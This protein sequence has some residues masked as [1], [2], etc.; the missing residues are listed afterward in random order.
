MKRLCKFVCLLLLIALTMV[1]CQ[2]S[3]FDGSRASNDEQFILD[4]DVL[5]CEKEHNLKLEKGMKLDVEIV[6]QSGRIDVK[7]VGTTG[8]VLYKGDNASSNSFVLTAQ[9]T[10]T[11]KISVKGKDA[12]GRISF[13]RRL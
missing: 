7:V 11:Y 2:K 6:N 5:N 12:K 8:N 4:Y 10:D 9:T 1:G 13:K 3:E